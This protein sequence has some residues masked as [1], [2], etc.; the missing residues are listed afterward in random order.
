MLVSKKAIHELVLPRRPLAVYVIPFQAE[1]DK[2][3]T[4][5]KTPGAAA[6]LGNSGPEDILRR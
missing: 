2:N 4:P 6:L 1:L 5:T 3:M